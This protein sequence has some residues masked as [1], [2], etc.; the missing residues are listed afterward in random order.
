MLCH[1]T[2]G[3]EDAFGKSLSSNGQTGLAPETVNFRTLLHKLHAGADLDHAD[4]YLGGAY[5]DVEFPANPGGV[6]NCTSCHGQD[7]TAYMQPIDRSYPVDD[8]TKAKGWNATCGA[9]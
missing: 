9:C 4:T 5:A 8:G 7:N 3:A 1:G 6:A 2:A